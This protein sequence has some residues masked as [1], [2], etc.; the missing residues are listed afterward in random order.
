MLY[1]S[2]PRGGV[3]SIVFRSGQVAGW[4]RTDYPSR[5]IVNQ[6]FFGV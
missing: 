1:L 6:R 5:V 3:I 4:P 2:V